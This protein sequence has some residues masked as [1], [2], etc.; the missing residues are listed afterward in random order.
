[1]PSTDLAI[2]FICFGSRSRDKPGFFNTIAA[3]KVLPFESVANRFITPDYVTGGV[4]SIISPRS[5]GWSGIGEWRCLKIIFLIYKCISSCSKLLLR[6]NRSWKTDRWWLVCLASNIQQ[7]G[8]LVSR[9]V[10]RSSINAILAVRASGNSWSYCSISG[11]TSKIFFPLD[12][13]NYSPRWYLRSRSQLLDSN[14]ATICEPPSLDH[15]IWILI[16]SRAN[17]MNLDRAEKEP[18]CI[19]RK[20]DLGLSRCR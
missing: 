2:W 9:S 12:V 15:R 4:W 6:Q 16:S 20:R 8:D 14:I 1:V 13:H 7:N 11:Y 17:Q 19:K 10:N 5:D 3:L 18:A